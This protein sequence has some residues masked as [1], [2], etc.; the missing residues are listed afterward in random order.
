[1]NNV[2]SFETEE[3]GATLIDAPPPPP[4]GA[5]LTRIDRTVLTPTVLDIPAVRDAI[6]AAKD[7]AGL[8]RYA[9]LI[10]I[11]LVVLAVVLGIVAA[12]R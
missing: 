3:I 4:P 10:G 11:G 8:P 2:F 1:M 9:L 6:P 12:I 5:H 7:A